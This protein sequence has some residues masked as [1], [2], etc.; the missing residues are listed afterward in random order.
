MLSKKTLLEELTTLLRTHLSPDCYTETLTGGLPMHI[1]FV[2]IEPWVYGCNT[3]TLDGAWQLSVETSLWYNRTP[4]MVHQWEKDWSFRVP[5]YMLNPEFEAAIEPENRHR[6]E[7]S[8]DLD[9]KCFA[10]ALAE[11]QKDCAF[12]TDQVEMIETVMGM[13]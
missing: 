4:V 5:L 9:P 12:R 7:W 6:F 1:P 10:L 8:V 13:K 2:R 11:Y 3:V